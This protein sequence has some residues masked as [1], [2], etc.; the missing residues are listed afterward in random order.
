MSLNL[1][2]MWNSSRKNKV[3]LNTNIRKINKPNKIT[4]PK[5]TSFNQTHQINQEQKAF[6]VCQHGYYFIL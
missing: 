2:N 4:I 3:I 6:G 5:P 1:G